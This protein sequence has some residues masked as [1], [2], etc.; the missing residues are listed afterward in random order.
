MAWLDELSGNGIADGVLAVKADGFAGEVAYFLRNSSRFCHSG[1]RSQVAVHD[2]KPGQGG[3]WLLQG[4][5]D[6]RILRVETAAGY[7]VFTDGLAGHGHAVIIQKRLHLTL[8]LRDA[9]CFIEIL[10]VE[11]LGSRIDAADE[12]DIVSVFLKP[13]HDSL[14]IQSNLMGNGEGVDNTVGGTS[15][16]HKDHDGI[17]N[18]L[19]SQDIPGGDAVQYHVDC[20]LAGEKCCTDPV[21]VNGRD[22]SGARQ[23]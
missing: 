3:E 10:G 8:N 2:G 22:S 1:V 12:W 16:C 15:S 11:F 14:G 17:A 23:A 19:R 7:S 9:A 4:G 18:G 13:S 5:D 6:L 21:I 20:R